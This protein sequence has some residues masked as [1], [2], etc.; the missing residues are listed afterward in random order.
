MNRKYYSG[1]HNTRQNHEVMHLHLWAFCCVSY[2]IHEL[3]YQKIPL[4]K[5]MKYSTSL[6]VLWITDLGKDNSPC[7]TIFFNGKDNISFSF[8]DFSFLVPQFSL[9]TSETLGMLLQIYGISHCWRL[10][11]DCAWLENLILVHVLV[12]HFCLW[13]VVG[14]PNGTKFYSASPIMILH[15]N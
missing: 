13:Q 4:N 2:S 15:R 9:R 1:K 11:R 7:T 3:P 10:E 8:S 6:A 12:S 5:D 14:F